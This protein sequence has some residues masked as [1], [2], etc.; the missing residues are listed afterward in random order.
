MAAADAS[1][2][3]YEL[4]DFGDGRKLERFGDIVLDLIRRGAD[5]GNRLGEARPE[6]FEV[7]LKLE[8][9]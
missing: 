3:D 7:D 5:R 1:T 6:F 4:L 2:G 9:K 8:R